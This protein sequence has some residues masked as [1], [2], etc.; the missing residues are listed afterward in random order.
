MR[1]EQTRSWG[2]QPH[3]TAV[4]AP[5]RSTLTGNTATPY[6]SDPTAFSRGLF[7]QFFLLGSNQERAGSSLVVSCVSIGVGETNMVDPNKV[8]QKITLFTIPSNATDVLQ[9]LRDSYSALSEGEVLTG[10][11]Q[12]VLAAVKIT[13]KHLSRAG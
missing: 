7:H 12:A 11:D 2:N 9:R 13:L 4:F 5:K 1:R 3:S 10:P 8:Q 6:A